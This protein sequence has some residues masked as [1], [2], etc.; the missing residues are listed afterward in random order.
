MVS[1]ISKWYRWLANAGVT[2][3]SDMRTTLRMRTLNG[4]YVF[5]ACFSLLY[6]FVALLQLHFLAMFF[7]MIMAGLCLSVPFLH[8]YQ[9]P[10]AVIIIHLLVSGVG[11]LMCSILLGFYSGF[12]LMLLCSPLS[13]LVF[14]GVS[15]SRAAAAALTFYMSLF[16]IASILNNSKLDRQDLPHPEFFFLVNAILTAV[17]SLMLARHF[18][19]ANDAYANELKEKNELMAHKNKEILQT[20]ETLLQSNEKIKGLVTELNDKVKNNLQ[21][22]TVFAQIDSFEKPTN[23]LDLWIKLSAS[24]LRVLD[25]SYQMMFAQNTP[26]EEW[27]PVFLT[28]Y[29]V[30]I[31]KNYIPRT[32]TA[33]TFA[34]L[35][36]M[37]LHL[38]SKQFDALMLLFNE[39]Y[40]QIVI[41]LTTPAKLAISLEVMQEAANSYA[42]RFRVANYICTAP[43]IAPIAANILKLAA[44]QNIKIDV[45]YSVS[46][47]TL[48]LSL[49]FKRM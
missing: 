13:V 1:L 8:H 39:L 5:C 35:Q 33:S 19:Q 15:N 24:R 41:G 7:S 23:D 31:N 11:L 21:V 14:F 20:N 25:I 49:I 45:A 18:A 40:F 48:T 17:I 28:K 27:L 22:M 29:F 3:D 42:L 30:F 44:Q 37:D 12:P 9:Q 38:S 26:S 4:V 47:Q 6:A 10:R 2:A 32:N 46:K 16:T 36:N 43:A 34:V